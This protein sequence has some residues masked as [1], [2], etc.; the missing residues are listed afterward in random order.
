MPKTLYSYLARGSFLLLPVVVLWGCSQ[1]STNPGSVAFNNLTA[2]YNA[3][4]IARTETEIA[5]RAMRKA[6]QENYNQI[7]PILLPLD[8]TLAM[9]VRPQLENAIEKASIVAERHQNSKWLDDSYTLIGKN[10]LY[11][12]QF[13]DGVEALRYVFTNGR[14]EDDKNKALIWLMRAYTQKQDYS[15]ALNVAEYLSQQPLNKEAT[16]DFYLAKAYVHQ[17]QGEYLTAVAILEQAFPL[18]KRGAEKARLHFAAGQL[19]DRINQYALAADHYRAVGKN[20][21]DYDLSF[22]AD[23]SSLQNRVLLNPNVDL[24]SVGFDKM[25]RD[26]KNN[27]LQDRI[28]YTMG[29]LAERRGRYPEAVEYLQKSVTT[30]GANVERIPYTYLELARINYDRLENYENAQAYYD[31]ALVSL[32]PQTEQFKTI[33]DRKKALDEFVA[34]MTIVRTEDSLQA[35]AQMNPAAL[36]RKLDVIIQAEEDEKKRLLAEAQ[37][38]LEASS[39]PS[40]ADIGTPFINGNERR[41][42]L[43]DPLLVNQGKVE[44]RRLWGSRPLE[45]DWRRATKENA[46]F[47]TGTQ[48][49]GNKP[50]GTEVTA[51]TTPPGVPSGLT[52]ETGMVNGSVAWLARRDE[53]RKNVPISGADFTASERREEDALYNLGKIYRFDLKESEKAVSTFTRLLKDFPKSAYREEIYY[54]IY[55]SLEEGDKNRPL[56]KEKLLAEFPNSTYARLL[57][58]ELTAGKSGGVPGSSANE[59]YDKLFG[60]YSAGN[61]TEALAQTENALALYRDSPLVDKFALLRIFLVGKVRGRDDYLQAI[62]EFIRLY[63]DSSLLPRV[64]EMLEV[65]GR[66]SIRR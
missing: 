33:S 52:P 53:L 57:N 19:Y 66:A 54:L 48:I 34:Q 63:P 47:N 20:R 30:A 27:D 46:S 60:L 45:D 16:R 24:S 23:M 14:D 43:Y 12:G 15:N 39:R 11:L 44:F 41:W 58:Q 49:V 28:Y 10:R 5:E 64:Q 59:A 3:Y 40:A 21:P 61:Y 2:K 36:D 56:W 25:L 37:K 29:L 32:P 35:L 51:T 55:L 18:L 7:L 62:N 6:Y 4:Y 8:S 22:Y 31:S 26:R 42:E 38:A 17:R 65:T 13:D 9:S 1:Y 50:P